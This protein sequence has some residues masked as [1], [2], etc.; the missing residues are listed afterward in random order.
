MKAKSKFLSAFIAASMVFAA[1]PFTAYGASKA[2]SVDGQEYAKHNRSTKH[3]SL[4]VKK[5]NVKK[6]KGVTARARSRPAKRPKTAA[7]SK[8]K[9][10]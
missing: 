3:A 2:A 7:A 10:S 8:L 9:A 4:D 5:I 1:V 6:V